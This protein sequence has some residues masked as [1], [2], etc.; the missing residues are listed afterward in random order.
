MKKYRLDIF[1]EA[2]SPAYDKE[3]ERVVGPLGA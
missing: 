1:Y 2:F 3:I